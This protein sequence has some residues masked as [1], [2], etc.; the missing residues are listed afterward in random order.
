[1]RLL[2]LLFDGNLIEWKIRLNTKKEK[3]NIYKKNT[4]GN[5]VT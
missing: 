2:L 4:A 1:M 5:R 3:M